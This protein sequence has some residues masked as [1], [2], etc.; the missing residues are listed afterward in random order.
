[1][2]SKPQIL[3]LIP[4]YHTNMVGWVESLLSR[5]IEVRIIATRR[6]F[7]E[8]H[9]QVEPCVL[10]TSISRVMS[11]IPLSKALKVKLTSPK[12]SIIFQEVKQINASRIVVRFELDLVS[13]KFLLVA[14]LQGVPVFIYTQ[15][16][17]INPP[18]I[19]KMILVFFVKILKLPTF[20]P[21]YDYGH[22]KLDFNSIE[23]AHKLNFDLEVKK[24]YSKHKLLQWIPFTL[25]QSFTQANE[26]SLGEVNKSIIH[27]TT[28][29][30]FMRR[31]NLI[32]I[33][34]VFCKN[35]MFL[36]SDSVLTIIG[37]STTEEH[38]AVQQELSQALE[39]H[40]MLDKVK[41]LTNLSRD[42][43]RNILVSSQVF[44]LQSSNEPA[45]ISILEAMGT[46]NVLILDP[47]SGTASYAGEN[48][49]ALAAS[50]QDELNQCIDKV[51]MDSALIAK[52]QNR[53]RQIFEEHFSNGVVGSH[54]YNFLF[55]DML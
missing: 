28:I 16:P 32:M 1:M 12:L 22:A 43:V 31:K 47:T 13:L 11:L 46:G 20:S 34:E 45:S 18:T 51:F 29:G 40:A 21:V 25:S 33:L 5:D 54:L 55:Q 42:E 41:I 4:R 27:F 7:S 30:K 49:G 19:K 15:W 9:G 37:E 38:T 52:L 10:P 17:V 44:L 6:E 26:K 50:S 53:S 36:R 35:Q 8:D 48:Y 14:R 39:N 3:F 23:N 2:N 24:K